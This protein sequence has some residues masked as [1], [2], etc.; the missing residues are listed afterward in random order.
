M[1][2]ASATIPQTSNGADARSPEHADNNYIVN[3]VKRNF[4]QVS[5]HSRDSNPQIRSGRSLFSI[6]ENPKRKNFCGPARL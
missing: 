2:T 6:L 4:L 5:S 1:N 3:S